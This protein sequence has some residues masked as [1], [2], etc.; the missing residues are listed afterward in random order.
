MHKLR[1]TSIFILIETHLDINELWIP[2]LYHLKICQIKL[3]YVISLYR[4]LSGG[5]S[6]SDNVG[7][8]NSGV[9]F[10]LAQPYEVS[11]TAIFPLLHTK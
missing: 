5:K 11:L 10:V 4:L 6:L 3:Q 7:I 2:I 1:L 8:G 9:S